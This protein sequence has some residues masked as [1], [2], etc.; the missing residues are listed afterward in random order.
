MLTK[1]SIQSF[2]SIHHIQDLELG[3]VNVFVGANGSGKSNLLEAVG[4]LSAAAAGRIDSASLRE[5]GVRLSPPQ[6]YIA[7]LKQQLSIPPQIHT[8][9]WLDQ[10]SLEYGITLHPSQT[11]IARLDALEVLSGADITFN[12]NGMSNVSSDENRALRE[13][14]EQYLTKGLFAFLLNLGKLPAQ[15]ETLNAILSDYAIYAPTTPVLRA[16]QSDIFTRDPMGL[17]GGRLAEAVEDILNLEQKTFGSL[18]LDELLELLGWV[19]EFDITAPSRE[20]LSPDVPSLRSIIRFKDFWMG[21][22]RNQLSG[23]DANEGALYVLFMLV[24]ALHPRVPRFFAV[25]NFDQMLH[26]R[27]ARALTRLFCRLVLE[28]EP[29]RQVLLTTHNPMVLDGLDLRDER[30][31][32]F[33]VERNQN[34]GGATIVRRVELSEAVL[35]TAQNGMPLSMMWVSGLLGGV[36]DIF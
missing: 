34:S 9:S 2:K 17:L 3:Q 26:P 24:L 6:L 21:E 32:L 33:T 1:I 15:A 16:I 10:Y 28:T 22:G 5:R 18:A 11:D 29:K 7:S 27:L 20:L 19:E 36:P 13:S 23:Y 4:V 14:K 25:D 30:V 35:A 12:T 31:R 8:T